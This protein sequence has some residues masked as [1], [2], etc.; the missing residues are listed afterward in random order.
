MAT[1]RSKRAAGVPAENPEGLTYPKRKKRNTKTTKK[2]KPVKEKKRKNRKLAN[3]KNI[4]LSVKDIPK[5]HAPKPKDRN[6]RDFAKFYG[7]NFFEVVRKQTVKRWKAGYRI[8][9]STLKKYDLVNEYREWKQ[10]K[11]DEGQEGFQIHLDILDDEILLEK[12]Q[13]KAIADYINPTAKRVANALQ[14]QSI[15]S[16]IDAENITILINSDNTPEV[17]N[18]NINLNANWSIKQQALKTRKKKQVEAEDEFDDADDTAFDD[19]FQAAAAINTKKAQKGKKKKSFF[20]YNDV[21]EWFNS[22]SHQVELRGR[23]GWKKAEQSTIDKNIKAIEKL[24]NFLACASGDNRK[25]QKVAGNPITNK[26][27]N[28]P[29]KL[30]P[31]KVPKNELKTGKKNTEDNRHFT[32]YGRLVPRGDE[33]LLECFMGDPEEVR[34]KVELIKQAKKKD[35]TPYARQ[36][37]DVIGSIQALFRQRSNSEKYFNWMRALVGEE[38]LEIWEQNF[39]TTLNKDKKAREKKR[40][41]GVLKSIPWKEI[42]NI[43]MKLKKNYETLKANPK[44]TD[45]ALAKANLDYVLWACYT[46]RPPVRDNYGNMKIVEKS[47]NTILNQQEYDKTVQ[48]EFDDS[49]KQYIPKGGKLEMKKNENNKNELFNYYSIKDKM[50]V[51]QLYKTR[52]LYRQRRD[53][54]NELEPIFGKGKLLAKI[55]KE[56]YDLVP[57]EWLFGKCGLDKKTKKVVVTRVISK[58]KEDTVARL[59]KNG[60]EKDIEKQGALSPYLA[61]IQKRYNLKNPS[62]QLGVRLFRHSFISYMYQIKK[63]DSDQKL[64][65]SYLMNHSTEEAKRYN[66]TLEDKTAAGNKLAPEFLRLK[67]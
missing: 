20:T 35:G 55:I 46:L 10:A 41:S 7:L 24:M 36:N 53:K 48:I 8:K 18:K 31:R 28:V 64:Q 50:F 23:K 62:G 27:N 3:K 49:G 57:R 5:K 61:K 29:G 17:D 47:I 44:T 13:E 66:W 1:R 51:L 26:K 6:K 12:R 60:I 25:F 22:D 63:I 33:N 59:D 67:K 32:P 34:Q 54:L 45:L 42:V 58:K 56:S 11:V 30:V 15:G 40:T 21:V 14:S 4:K 39:S 38:Q 2:T 19:D 37:A 9:Y 52:S 16:S 43:F 65:L